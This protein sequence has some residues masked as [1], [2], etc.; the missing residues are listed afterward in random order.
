MENAAYV[1]RLT[2]ED[3]PNISSIW[4]KA[5]TLQTSSSVSSATFG[6]SVTLSC[7]DVDNMCYI[8]V[9][10]RLF[11]GGKGAVYV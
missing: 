9:V 3:G 7:L 2:T 1:Y 5:A 6:S 10:D 8:V 4:I 11:N